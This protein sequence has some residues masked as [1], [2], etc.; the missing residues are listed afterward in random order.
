[1]ALESDND[2]LAAYR[3]ALEDGSLFMQRCDASRQSHCYVTHVQWARVAEGIAAMGGRSDPLL[4]IA[5]DVLWHMPCPARDG[6]FIA[7]I[8]ACVHDGI[9]HGYQPAGSSVQHGFRPAARDYSLAER[10]LVD[11]LVAQALRPVTGER[12]D[13]VRSALCHELGISA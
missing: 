12:D 9:A 2:E 1:M 4:Q 5:R 8:W 11:V 3:A 6:A 7:A 13:S 10:L